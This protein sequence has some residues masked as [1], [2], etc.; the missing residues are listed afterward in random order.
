M[1]EV[2][3]ESRE[4]AAGLVKSMEAD[5]A[6]NGVTVAERLQQIR[7]MGHVKYAGHFERAYR[8]AKEIVCGHE[9]IPPHGKADTD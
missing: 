2:Q 9:E 4:A 5:A 1:A 8:A 7:Q 3:F 6:R